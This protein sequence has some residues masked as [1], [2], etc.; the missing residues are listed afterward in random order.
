MPP[1][2]LAAISSLMAHIGPRVKDI[3][4]IGEVTTVVLGDDQ[5]LVIENLYFDLAGTRCS[6]TIAR[7][8]G[9]AYPRLAETA[10]AS[11]REHLG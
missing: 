5:G 6:L 9:H 4:P 2:T 11:I 10:A 8:K 3:L 1:D 7:E